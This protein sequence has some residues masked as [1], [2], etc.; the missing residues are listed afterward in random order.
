[1]IQT[2]LKTPVMRKAYCQWV[3][4]GRTT[5]GIASGATIAP[6]FVPALK[7]P[8][9]KALSLCGNHSAI[10]LIPAGKFPD[11]PS[12]SPNLAMLKP[13]RLNAGRTSAWSIPKRLQTPTDRA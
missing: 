7:M 1:M 6:T 12:P 3:P 8:V 2:T 10:V 4:S 5:S 11:S 9:A 13:M